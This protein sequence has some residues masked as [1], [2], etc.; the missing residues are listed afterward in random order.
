MLVGAF[1]IN[2]QPSTPFDHTLKRRQHCSH[3]LGA[4][5]HDLN[6]HQERIYV[7]E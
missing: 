6:Q 3:S 5:I 1:W 4:K 2:I 7:T